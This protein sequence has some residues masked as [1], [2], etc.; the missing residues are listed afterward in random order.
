MCVR[1]GRVNSP[2]SF[3]ARCTPQITEMQCRVPVCVVFAYEQPLAPTL[4]HVCLRFEDLRRPSA[5]SKSELVYGRTADINF[6]ESVSLA[7]R[8]EWFVKSEW[9]G[10]GF[11]QNPRPMLELVIDRRCISLAHRSEIEVLY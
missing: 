5:G 4:Q 9:P 1:A 8:R 11:M 10:F 6:A 2:L 7:P 3:S